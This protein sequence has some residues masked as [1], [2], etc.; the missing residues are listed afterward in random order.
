LLRSLERYDETTR[1]LPAPA[2]VTA[3]TAC[4][5]A[6]DRVRVEVGGVAVAELER[7]ELDHLNLATG[8]SWTPELRS[9]V[10]GCLARRLARAAA[11]QALGRR[12]MSRH[13]LVQRLVDRGHAREDARCVVDDLA[14]EGWQSDREHAEAV[15]RRLLEGRPAAPRFVVDRLVAAGID[16]GLAEEVTRVALADR[17]PLA[18]AETLARQRLGAMSTLSPATAARRVGGQLARR[19]FDH[20]EIGQVLDRLGL[21]I[22]DE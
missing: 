21:R 12:S 13:Q 5:A 1:G 18:A 19:G 2:S 3:L 15:C 9:A 17:D 6:P 11:M 7:P 10:R 16:Q 14:A 20:E 22:P 8:Q 4:S